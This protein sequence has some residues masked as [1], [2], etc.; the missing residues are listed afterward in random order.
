MLAG[1]PR[2]IASAWSTST[3]PA[4]RA[5]RRATST[6]STIATP[7][8]T[9]SST[10]CI[11]GEGVWW[12]TSRRGTSASS[13]GR[14]AGVRRRALGWDVHRCGSSSTSP[15]AD[16]R[17]WLV[18]WR[19]RDGGSGIPDPG[20]A[21]QWA[22]RYTPSVEVVN[23]FVDELRQAGPGREVPYVAPHYDARGRTRALAGA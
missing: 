19:V 21:Q 23:R 7:S 17:R 22:D 8:F 18:G 2:R 5:G 9:A 13:P 14:R 11:A 15:R 6:S 10:A 1:V 16:V 4:D 3:A 12:T 20:R